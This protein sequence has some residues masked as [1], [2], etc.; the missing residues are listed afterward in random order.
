MKQTILLTGCAGFIGSN[1]VKKITTEKSISN[2]WN[3][4]IVDALTYAGRLQTIQED[5]DKNPHLSFEKVDIRNAEAVTAVFKKTKPAG[6]IHFAAESHVDRSILNPNI[7]VE[8]N[9]LGTLN[10]LN[11]SLEFAKTNTHFK[12]V[13][14][15]TDEVY[16]SLTEDAP[17]FT[18]KHS[19]QAN[20]PY[21]ASKASSD[22]LVRAYA[23]T[24][25]LNTCITRCSN[26]YGP[27]QF[28]EKL[29]PLMTLNS[30]NN[31]KLPVYGNGKNIR[32]WF[33]VDD[34]N[35]GVWAVF[36]K[37]RAGEVYNF[38]GASERRNVDV[39]KEILKITGKPESLIDY[40][41][42]RKGHDWRYAID[43]TKA[44]NELHWEPLVSF[45]DG[46]QLT[47]NWYKDNTSWIEMTQKEL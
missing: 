13:H 47:V 45:E 29:I 35:R 30:L 14:V 16:G 7:F 33:F 3:F 39:V 34:H 10:L 5:L 18:E 21:S 24:Y 32:D 36:E 37:G 17:A 28:P 38:G 40:V 25:K 19:L 31:K 6:V 27:Y 20:S 4:V 43:F 46:L 2:K 26:N 41:E 23:E 11:N 1:F 15:S 12:F 42:D 44:K 22:L 8:T 9:V